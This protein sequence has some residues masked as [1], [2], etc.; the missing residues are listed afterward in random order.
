M[1]DSRALLYANGLNENTVRQLTWMD[2]QGKTLGTVGEPGSC[3]SNTRK[4]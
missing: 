4:S 2:R 1:S 3:Q